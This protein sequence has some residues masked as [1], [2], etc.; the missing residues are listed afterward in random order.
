M[1][2]PNWEHLKRR[3]VLVL[4]LTQARNQRTKEHAKFAEVKLKIGGFHSVQVL[5]MLKIQFQTALFLDGGSL[6]RTHHHV[7]SRVLFAVSGVPKSKQWLV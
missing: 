7:S 6:N 4:G 1:E 3:R 5:N 2:N